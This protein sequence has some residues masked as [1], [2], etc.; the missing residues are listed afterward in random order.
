MDLTQG[1]WIGVLDSLR[2][3][4][5]RRLRSSRFRGLT[6]CGA[7]ATWL[8]RAEEVMDWGWDRNQKELWDYVQ[9]KTDQNPWLA[10]HRDWFIEEDKEL[11]QRLSRHC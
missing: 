1:H 6:V 7:H 10:Y 5:L 9:H 2:R 8:S 3:G 4:N 11:H